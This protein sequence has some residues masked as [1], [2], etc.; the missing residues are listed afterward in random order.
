MNESRPGLLRPVILAAGIAL[1]GGLIGHGFV[2]ARA[3]DRF[4]TVKGIS[5]RKVQADIAFWP[6]MLSAADNDLHAAQAR[7]D[8]QMEQVKAFL[9]KQE[10][11]PSG[12]EVQSPSVSDAWTN[13][14]QDRTKVAT[15]FV[16]NQTLMVSS[17]KPQA[18]ASA[19]RKVGELVSAGMVLN[20]G[21]GPIFMFT[22]LNDIKP[23]MIAEAT[24]RARE[25]AEQF[26]RDSGGRLDG[27]RQA[28]QGVFEIQPRDPIP[29]ASEESQ[30][31]K[32]VR[33]VTT[34]QYA[35]AG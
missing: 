34:V 14:Y 3:S 12:F 4:V 18:V 30:M 15:R 19:S 6:I 28:S 31:N 21:Q 20:S 29:G 5:E 23:E 32:T 17:E 25:G 33:V 8:A 27:I 26:A 22:R 11:D 24:K 9:V 10:L 7:V 16:V 35:L 13:Q 2:R 1:A